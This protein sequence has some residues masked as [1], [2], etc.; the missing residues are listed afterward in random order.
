MPG[1]RSP[2]FKKI[3]AAAKKVS[4]RFFWERVPAAELVCLLAY[5]QIRKHDVK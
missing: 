3:A 1:S 5:T 2:R 4:G